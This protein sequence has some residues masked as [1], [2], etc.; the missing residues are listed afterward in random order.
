MPSVRPVAGR[1]TFRSTTSTDCLKAP[2]DTSVCFASPTFDLSDQANGATLGHA[3]AAVP[4]T[5]AQRSSIVAFEVS[6]FTAQIFDNS[7]KELKA[8]QA[9]GGAANLATRSFY[10]GINDVVSG[11][12]RTGAAFTPTVFTLYDAWANAPGGGTNTARRAVARGQALFNSKPIAISGVKGINDDLI[13]AVLPGTCTTCHDTPSAGN[14]SIPAPLDIGL[15]DA[16][17]RTADMP[18]Y[19]LRRNSTGETIKTTDPGRALIT[20]KWKDIG[21]FKGPILRALSG[22]APYFHNGSASDL[23]SAV[24]FYNSRFGIGFTSAERADLIAFLQ[25]L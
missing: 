14:H 22:R 4:L 16:S 5:Q 19:T 1:E 6:L 7:A 20:G 21:R 2:L 15:T 18:L 17:R 3:E 8:A 24:D 23:G 12:Y 11:D 25:T 10:F 13:V 9:D